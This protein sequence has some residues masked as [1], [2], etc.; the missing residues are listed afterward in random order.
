VLVRR[1]RK[2][3][4]SFLTQLCAILGGVFTVTGLVDGIVYHGSATLKRKMQVGKLI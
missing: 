4:A 2:S 1:E 3:F